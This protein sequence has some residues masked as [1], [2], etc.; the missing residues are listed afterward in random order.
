MQGGRV[1]ADAVRG[2]GD[3]AHKELG[4][5]WEAPPRIYVRTLE[6]ARRL[7]V[8]AGGAVVSEPVAEWEIAVVHFPFAPG[9]VPTLVTALELGRT[10]RGRELLAGVRDRLFAGWADA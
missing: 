3:L 6:D 9:Q 5:L 7:V 4:V 10:P 2:G 8:L 1:P